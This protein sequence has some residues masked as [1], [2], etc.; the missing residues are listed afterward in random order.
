MHDS[1]NV[2]APCDDATPEDITEDQREKARRL[3]AG[4]PGHDAAI[5][6]EILLTL[7]IYPGQEVETFKVPLAFFQNP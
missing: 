7:G 3:V 6:A 5:T 1:R 4:W 2:T